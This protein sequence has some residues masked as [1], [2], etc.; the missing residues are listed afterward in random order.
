MLRFVMYIVRHC[1]S[2]QTSTGRLEAAF[3]H[4]F[5]VCIEFTSSGLIECL[6]LAYALVFRLY[7]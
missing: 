2:I 6:S 7:F 5:R 4:I 3:H 1:S